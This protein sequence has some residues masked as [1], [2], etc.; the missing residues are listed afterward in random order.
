[1]KGM[2][3]FIYVIIQISSSTINGVIK[4]KNGMVI[5][6]AKVE[7]ILKSKGIIRGTY[8]D[9]N[10]RYKFNLMETGGPYTLLIRKEGYRIYEKNGLDFELGDNDLR[11][12][13]EREF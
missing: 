6:H 8:T 4:D 1:M 11:S 7:L 10:G 5:N 9:E 13:I 12:V 3:L 2:F